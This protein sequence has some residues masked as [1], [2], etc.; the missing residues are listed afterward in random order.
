M[1]FIAD[2]LDFLIVGGTTAPS[3]SAIL[4]NRDHFEQILT[5][6]AIV[7]RVPTQFSEVNTEYY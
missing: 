7:Q 6:L 3:S 2:F 5:K 1:W 4:N